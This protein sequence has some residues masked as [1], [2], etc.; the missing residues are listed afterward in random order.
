M[1]LPG[2]YAT[3]RRQIW[4]RVTGS[5]V[6]V[7]GKRRE[8]DLLIYPYDARP[9]GVTLHGARAARRLAA[10]AVDPGRRIWPGIDIRGCRRIGTIGTVKH[11]IIV[12]PGAAG[13]STLA[14]PLGEMSRII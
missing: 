12:G 7:T 11:V 6:T 2:R 5:W 4:Q 14:A 10:E 3:V 9:D 13:K 8:D 1:R